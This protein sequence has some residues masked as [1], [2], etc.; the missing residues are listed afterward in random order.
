[1]SNSMFSDTQVIDKT[2]VMAGD[3][4]SKILIVAINKDIPYTEF[5]DP[6]ELVSGDTP[7]LQTSDDAYE[8]AVAI[9]SQSPTVKTKAIYGEDK[10]TSTNTTAEEILLNLYEQGKDNFAAITNAFFGV[11]DIK[12]LC[13]VIAIKGITG[14]IQLDAGTSVSAAKTLY[15]EINLKKVLLV[16]TDKDDK[17]AGRICGGT[18]PFFPGS[19]NTAGMVLQGAK[20]AGYTTTEIKELKALGIVTHVI[21]S[22]SGGLDYGACTQAKGTDGTWFDIAIAEQWLIKENNRRVNSAIMNNPSI[23]F[24]DDGTSMFA[25]IVNELVAKGVKGGAFLGNKDKSPKGFSM[26][27]TPVDDIS[28][29]D[30]GQR[31]Y[32]QK[33]KLRILNKIH[34]T[35]TTYEVTN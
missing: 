16:M 35:E 3:D 1:M 6:A 32:K 10:A 22:R 11:E 13:K 25:A 7:L 17:L 31:K 12:S 18:Y 20:I 14:V 26:K 30:L 5:E 8:I 19:I 2:K 34:E 28:K 23:G 29:D 24:D 21:G 4:H 9:H 27:I 33:C 15:A